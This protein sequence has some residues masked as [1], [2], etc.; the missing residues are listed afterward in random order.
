MYQSIEEYSKDLISVKEVC[1]LL[2]IGVNGLQYRIKKQGFPKRK[3]KG[4]FSRRE[5]LEWLEKEN[6]R[7]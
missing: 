4:Y 5:I 6:V 1:E 7:E 2:H 3:V